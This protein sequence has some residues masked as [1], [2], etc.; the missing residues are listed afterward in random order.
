MLILQVSV[1]VL[2]YM[3]ILFMIKDEFVIET[4]NQ[5]RKKIKGGGK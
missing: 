4:F 2:V 1:G 3:T 5:L